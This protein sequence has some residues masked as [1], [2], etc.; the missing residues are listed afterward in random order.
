M[1]RVFGAQLETNQYEYIVSFGCA[2]PCALPA[3]N[4]IDTNSDE[5]YD[6]VP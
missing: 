1:H 5:V 6:L 3:L 2:C 4:D